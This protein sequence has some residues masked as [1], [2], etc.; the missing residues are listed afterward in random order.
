SVLCDPNELESA[1]LNL[2]I[3]ARDAMPDGGRLA[4]H[5][6]VLDIS[7]AD[8]SGGEAAPGAYVEISVRDTGMGMPPEV[9]ARVFEPFFTTKPQGQGTGLGLS[10]V[11]GFIRQSDGLVRIESMPGRGTS[12]RLLLPLR[13]GVPAG[14][15]GPSPPAS[16]EVEAQGTV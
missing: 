14:A 13:E 15:E 3:N 8:L 2:C 7:A 10:Q 16:P 5:T 12:V 4:I 9:L 6:D 11:H 1:L